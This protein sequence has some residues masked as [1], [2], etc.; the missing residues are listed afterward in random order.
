I[1][2]E[3][4]PGD[5][6]LKEEGCMSNETPLGVVI[7]RLARADPDRPAITCGPDAVSRIELEAR[8]NRLARAYRD[9]GVTQDSFV[10]IGLPNGIAFFEATIAAWKLG[11]TPQ[12]I[13]SRLPAAERRAI[14]DLAN[15]SL[16]VGVEP[17]EAPGRAAIPVGYEPDRSLSPGPL[18][19]MVAASF[20]APT[21][22]GSTGRPKLIVATQAS[23]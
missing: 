4:D 21:S 22:G 12:P 16:V 15:P 3:I 1:R 5:P 13:S 17:S 19:P 14:I 20:K 18:P 7:G 10:T 11:A 6:G 23:V 8:T 9:L 2:G